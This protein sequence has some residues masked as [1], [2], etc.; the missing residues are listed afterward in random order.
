MN[1]LT[2]GSAFSLRRLELQR[3]LV[4]GR[5]QQQRLAQAR[6]QRDTSVP[7]HCEREF[8]NGVQTHARP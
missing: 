5:T 3:G 8:T 7:I 1:G 6:I 4:V 2:S